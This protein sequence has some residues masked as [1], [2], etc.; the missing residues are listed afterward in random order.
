M[1]DLEAPDPVGHT[2][3][4]RSS[5]PRTLALG[6]LLVVVA[7][8]CASDAPL[9][10]LDPKGPEAQS[11]DNLLLPVMLIAGVVFL[12]VE[13]GIVYLVVRLRKRTTTRSCPA[14]PT[15]TSC[16]SWAGRSC[17]R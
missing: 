9:D 2:R 1:T 7:A 16:S 4:V 13:L 17:P 6:L 11:I 12:F 15:A 5:R 8:G 3:P 10:T 14:R